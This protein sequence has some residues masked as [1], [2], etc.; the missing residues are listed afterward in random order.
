MCRASTRGPVC[1]LR[2]CSRAVGVSAIRGGCNG[3]TY[4]ELLPRLHET[5]SEGSFNPPRLLPQP[6]HERI[7][8][9]AIRKFAPACWVGSQRCVV[10]R[11]GISGRGSGLG[12]GRGPSRGGRGRLA[13]HDDE[14]EGLARLETRCVRDA[15]DIN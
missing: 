8:R 15:E 3:R 12:S 4:K 6:S 2:T 10:R 7:F 5:Q 14:R 11:E 13:T 9:R 1:S